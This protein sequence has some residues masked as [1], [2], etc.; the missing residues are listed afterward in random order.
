MTSEESRRI[1]TDLLSET[2]HWQDNYSDNQTVFIKVGASEPSNIAISRIVVSPRSKPV[3]SRPA[4]KTENTDL[5]ED[6]NIINENAIE[7]KQLS[8]N[9]E[10]Q[11]KSPSSSKASENREIV[12]KVDVTPERVG[13]IGIPKFRSISP[14]EPG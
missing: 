7:S 3:D 9:K 13:K 6:Q 1:R 14:P 8:E 12:L 5:L 11:S 2:K 4:T 10:I